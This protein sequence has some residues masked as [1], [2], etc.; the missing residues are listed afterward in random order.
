MIAEDLAC[1]ELVE[2]V[3][4]YLEGALAR[5]TRA[6]V[7]RHLAACPFCVTYVEQIRQIITTASAVAPRRLSPAAQQRLLEAFRGWHSVEPPHPQKSG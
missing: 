4:D 3:T 6:R 5:S 1:Q 7:E 2:F